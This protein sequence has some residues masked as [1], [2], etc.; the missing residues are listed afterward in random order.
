VVLATAV[1]AALHALLFKRE[2]RASLGWIA[3][4]LTLPLVGPLLYYVFGI[5]RIRTRAKRLTASDSEQIRHREGSGAPEALAQLDHFTLLSGATST[6]PE[7]GLQGLVRLSHLVTEMPL[8]PG[9]TVRMLRNGEEAFPAM[10]GA[11]REAETT[12]YL[13]TYIFESNTSGK[14]FVAALS[15][16]QQRGVVVRVL[17]DGVGE[18]YSWPRVR[19]MLSR[20]GVRVGRFLPPRIFPPQFNINLRNH[21]KILLIDGRR[22]FTGGMNIGDRSLADAAGN[23]RAADVHFEPSWRA[24]SSAPSVRRARRSSS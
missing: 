3:V 6:T 2:P 8:R 1:S 19:R 24:S 12:V 17:I 22:A 11:I 23:R 10:I 5:N 20:A 4:S 18:L 21:R 9:Q 13:A 7:T 15:E 14:E 16:A